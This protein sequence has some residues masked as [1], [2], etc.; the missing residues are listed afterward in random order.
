MGT[1]LTQKE[2]DDAAFLD[3]VGKGDVDKVSTMIAKGQ[4]LDAMTES[5][6]TGVHLA[7]NA[8][9]E[10]MLKLL[11]ANQAAIDVPDKK[12]VRPITIAVLLNQPKLFEILKNNRAD[13]TIVNPHS[14]STLLHTAVWAGHEEMV[15]LLLRTGAFKGELMEI[16]DADGRTALHLA[17]F[18]ASEAVCKMLIDAGAQ[19]VGAGDK[20]NMKPAALA[21]R[22]GRKKSKEYLQEC[23]TAFTAAMAA[24]KMK[25]KLKSKEIAATGVDDSA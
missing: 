12:G 16:E 22:S 11:V 6:E 2:L 18:R 19:G 25:G 23:E 4:K 24:V 7:V 5:G 17:A 14:Q 10:A 21:E 8:M 3:F 20:F 15:E 9:D 13:L 1:P